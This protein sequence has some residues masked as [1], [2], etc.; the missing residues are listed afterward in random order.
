MVS[1]EENN[2]YSNFC[3]KY[4]YSK[5]FAYIKIM[6]FFSLIIIFGFGAIDS[7][8]KGDLLYFIGLAYLS[9]MLFYVEYFIMIRIYKNEGVISTLWKVKFYLKSGGS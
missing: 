6:F 9:I 2:N 4:S 8:F 7:S 1:Q 5:G 3:I